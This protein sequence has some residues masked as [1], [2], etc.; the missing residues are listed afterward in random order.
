MTD[1]EKMILS[2]AIRSSIEAHK[3][4]YKLKKLLL[5]STFTYTMLF[6][7]LF[8]MFLGG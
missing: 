1:G 7:L 6:I 4:I 3:K 5:F 8:L 2:D